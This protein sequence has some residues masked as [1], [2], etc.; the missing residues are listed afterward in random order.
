MEYPKSVEIIPFEG[1][2]DLATARP[3]ALFLAEPKAGLRAA[4]PTLSR[5]RWWRFVQRKGD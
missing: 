3:P 1:P 2:R 4:K 5:W